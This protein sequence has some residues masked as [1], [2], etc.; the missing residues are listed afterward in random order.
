ME[1]EILIPEGPFPGLRPYADYESTI[2]YGR[3]RQVAEILKRLEQRHVVSVLGGSGSGKSSLVKAGVIPR[4]RQYG[5]AGTGHFWVPIVFTPGTNFKDET[6]GPYDNLA[7]SLIEPLNFD[8]IRAEHSL[9]NHTQ[10]EIHDLICRDI[11]SVLRNPDGLSEYIETYSRYIDI[12]GLPTSSS[13]NFLFVFDQFEEVFHASNENRSDVADFVESLLLGHYRNP[14]DRANVVITM[15][16]EYLNDC[17]RFIDLPDLINESGYLV[18]R[19]KLFEIKETIETPLKKY[20]RIVTRINREQ[21]EDYPENIAVDEDVMNRIL[22]DIQKLTNNPDH[23]PL[24]QHLLFRLWQVA[25]ARAEKQGELLPARITEQDL[26]A[27]IGSPG[28][29][30]YRQDMFNSC[31]DHWSNELFDSLLK[32]K[33]RE[34]KIEWFFVRM[35]YLDHNGKYSQ[36]R[37]SLDNIDEDIEQIIQAFTDPHSYLYIDRINNTAK[38]SHESF[39]RGWDKYVDWLKTEERQL[40]QYEFVTKEI[41]EQQSTGKFHWFN[42]GRHYL[43]NNEIKRVEDTGLFMKKNKSR[44]FRLLGSGESEEDYIQDKYKLTRGYLAVTHADDVISVRDFIKKSKFWVN[45]RRLPIIILLFAVLLIPWLLTLHFEKSYYDVYRNLTEIEK[46]IDRNGDWN[47]S[48]IV[49]YI[50]QI[51]LEAEKHNNIRKDIVFNSK[52]G[53]E[54]TLL[55]DSSRLWTWFMG[56]VKSIILKLIPGTTDTE[57]QTWNQRNAEPFSAEKITDLLLIT[58]ENKY[59]IVRGDSSGEDKQAPKS[60]EEIRDYECKQVLPDEQGGQAGEEKIITGT[61]VSPAISDGNTTVPAGI[62]MH[63][64]G[65]WNRAG[66]WI[67]SIDVY[68]AKLED[69]QCMLVGEAWN[70]GNFRPVMTKSEIVHINDYRLFFNPDLSMAYKVWSIDDKPNDAGPERQTVYISE[71]PL[72]RPQDPGSERPDLYYYRPY[73]TGQRGKLIFEKGEFPDKSTFM[74]NTDSYVID[75]RHEDNGTRLDIEDVS[76]KK[77]NFST[78]MES[79]TLTPENNWLEMSPRESASATGACSEMADKKYFQTVVEQ[80]GSQENITYW[81]N[82]EAKS[83]PSYCVISVNKSFDSNAVWDFYIFSSDRIRELG[84]RPAVRNFRARDS[85]ISAIFIGNEESNKDMIAV[86]TSQGHSVSR[87]WNN[88]SLIKMVTDLCQ[89]IDYHEGIETAPHCSPGKDRIDA[90][91]LEE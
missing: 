60:V 69:D 17:A 31:L 70:L 22:S 82:D 25:L 45:V 86:T 76:I 5:I 9:E 11:L 20:L 87:P 77:T 15:R 75:T 56:F 41:A 30:A 44:W 59:A 38:V 63:E 1:Y 79:S 81:A 14:N 73:A 32:K 7:H 68:S 66:D 50:P 62:F 27:A 49:N 61:L 33:I 8:K 21:S 24:L 51:L 55:Y 10:E 26:H 4:L 58:S 57:I 43:S 34:S 84:Y 64:T 2:F 42:L 46:Q 18:A 80:Y 12:E 72:I 28:D 36:Q 40:E 23:L 19:L 16:S 3:D 13:T 65:F 29:H 91:G 52:P 74:K 83:S 67:L 39:I 35:A 71:I 85:S 48:A 6:Q 37:I 53:F 89:N 54:T 47:T 88:T 90:A 78:R